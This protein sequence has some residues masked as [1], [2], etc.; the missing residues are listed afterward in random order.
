MS[1]IQSQFNTSVDS[2][3]T[4]KLRVSAYNAQTSTPWD[5][6]AYFGNNAVLDQAKSIELIT[7]SI[8]HTVPN[9]SADQGNNVFELI[10]TSGTFTYVVPQGFYSASQLS[11]ILQPLLNAFIS[12]SVSSFTIQSDGLFNI[13]ITSGPAQI[14]N[15]ANNS[16]GSLLGYET[17]NAFTTSLTADVLPT[18]QGI[19]Y[20]HIVS[21]QT[22]S[23]CYTNN[24]LTS[25]NYNTCLFSVPVLVPFGF[26]NV[27]Q[28]NNDQERVRFRGQLSLKNLDITLQD[29][30]GRVL[31]DMD[32]RSTVELIL[33]V[34]Y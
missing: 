2:E 7:C 9:I 26:M 3:N 1:I 22:G 17:L 21:K 29:E 14:R 8:S 10:T 6:T 25:T 18:L 28:N 19:T 20:F 34:I 27:F 13:T 33:K 4:I 11:T 30:K 16:V 15:S 5:F 32:P 23:N 12:P 24:S 31:T